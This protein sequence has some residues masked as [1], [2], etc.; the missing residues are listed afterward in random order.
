MDHVALQLWNTAK[1]KQLV[2]SR[3]P[4]INL[5]A[6]WISMTIGLVMASQALP[7]M[8]VPV[9]S[10][11]QVRCPFDFSDR[12]QLYDGHESLHGLERITRH[13]GLW[14]LALVSAAQASLQSSIPLR[15][16]WLG[17]SFVAYLGGG[18]TDSRFRRGIGGNLDPYYDSMTSNLPFAA[19]LSGKQGPVVQAVTELLQDIKPLNATIAT[20]VAT[21]W[22]LSRGRVKPS[23]R[24]V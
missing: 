7:K 3:P 20:G 21:A 22:I 6:A 18:H 14:S 23:L 13:P 10:S 4:T 11:F 16:W 9:D 15:L 24:P 17:P 8:Q 2:L 19:T 1:S 12:K 5:A